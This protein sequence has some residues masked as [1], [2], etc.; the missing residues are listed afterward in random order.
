MLGGDHVVLRLQHV[1][2]DA[3]HQFPLSV[4]GGRWGRWEGGVQCFWGIFKDTYDVFG[5]LYKYQNKARRVS[6]AVNI[7]VNSVLLYFLSLL[8]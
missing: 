2:L 1:V 8:S 4:C 6:H 7:G 5:A 3:V